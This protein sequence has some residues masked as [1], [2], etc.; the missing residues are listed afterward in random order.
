VGTYK[1]APGEELRVSRRINIMLFKS[2]DVSS[3][4]FSLVDLAHYLSSCSPSLSCRSSRRLWASLP[5]AATPLAAQSR[6]ERATA[7]HSLTRCVTRS[8]NLAWLPM[9]VLRLVNSAPALSLLSQKLAAKDTTV[10]C[11]TLADGLGRKCAFV[12]SEARPDQ[13]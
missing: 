4:Y 1:R 10:R 7:V 12:I 9:Y 6:L 5:P 11:F 2:T 8:H 13:H 3:R